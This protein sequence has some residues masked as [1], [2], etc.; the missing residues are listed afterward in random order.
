MIIQRRLA[1]PI[2]IYWPNYCIQILYKISLSFSN[3]PPAASAELCCTSA[4][5]HSQKEPIMDDA[6]ALYLCDLIKTYMSENSAICSHLTRP[7]AMQE[8]TELYCYTL[9]HPGRGLGWDKSILYFRWVIWDIL[10][11][12]FSELG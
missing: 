12:L 5:T 3:K 1:Q 11:S 10:C 9:K 2:I 7:N 4:K 8:C 6:A